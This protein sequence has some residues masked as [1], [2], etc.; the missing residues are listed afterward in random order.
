MP[1]IDATVIIVTFNSEAVIGACLEALGALRRAPRE[2]IVVDNAS[3][4]RSA[5]RVARQHPAVRLVRS[6]INLGFGPAC[7]RALELA[8][9]ALPVLLNPDTAVEP[10]WLEA[11]ERAL[12]SDPRLG[13]A[14]SKIL[15]PDGRTVQ[16][17]GGILHPNA[18]TDHAGR[19]EPDRPGDSELIDCDYVTGASAALRREMLRAIGGFDPG[20]HPAYFEET[21]LCW[22]AR[23]RGWRV[24]VAPG[25]RLRHVE[26]AATGKLSS[27]YLRHYHRNR[28]R[29]V[30]KNY[31]WHELS[32]RFWPAERDWIRSGNAAESIPALRRAWLR[33][34]W[35]LPRTLWTRMR[36]GP[37]LRV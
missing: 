11:L 8:Q 24:A 37:K 7:N 35:G 1:T 20:F 36:P 30:L 9:G 34:F 25:S 18:L 14:G 15:E 28:I 4:D 10:D 3:R 5:E 13:I 29:F 12:E 19:G 27:D 21:D 33:A 6:P 16:H 17:L 31:T 2:V 22:R 26:A 32:S 23:R